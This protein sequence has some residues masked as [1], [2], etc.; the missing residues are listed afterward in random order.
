M[1]GKKIG[2][3]RVSTPEQN[4]ER[5]LDSIELHKKFIDYCSGSHRDRPE[6][7]KMLDY[8]REEDI[9]YVHSMDRLGRN[10]K[11][12]LELVNELVNQGIEIRFLKEN[13]VIN[14]DES[15][16]SRMILT[17]WA[18]IAEMEY[19]SMR[20]RQREGIDKAR[21][22]GKYKQSKRAPKYR[23]E[24]IRHQLSTVKNR[25]ELAREL[26]VSRFTL[27][28]YLRDLKKE[29]EERK[30]VILEIKQG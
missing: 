30:K 19:Q 2:Y 5:Q 9:I 24:Q 11:E 10:A 14:G 28:K 23:V 29:E 12:L 1:T 6:L 20:E 16:M 18:H 21:K 22:A 3:I 13:L 26:G 15:T 7:K 8:C 27:Y 17:I 4:P 25:S